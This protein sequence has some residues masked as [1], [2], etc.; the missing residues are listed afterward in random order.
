[1]HVGDYENAMTYLHQSLTICRAL[2]DQAGEGTT[3][4]NLSLIY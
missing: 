1:M 4:N 3:L 2:G